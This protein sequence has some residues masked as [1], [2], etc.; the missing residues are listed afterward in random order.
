[1]KIDALPDSA[2][3]SVGKALTITTSLTGEG[4]SVAVWFHNGMV[5]RYGMRKLSVFM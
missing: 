3:V 5:V 1:M 4:P 2:S